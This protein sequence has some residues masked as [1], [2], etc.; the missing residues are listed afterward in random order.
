MTTLDSPVS[1]GLAALSA[2]PLRLAIGAY[3]GGMFKG[4]S[5][6]THPLGSKPPARTSP[7]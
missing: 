3:L 4:F 6:N 5:G 2:D 7:S 1:T